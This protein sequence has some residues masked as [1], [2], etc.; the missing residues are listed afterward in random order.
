MTTIQR[1]CFLLFDDFSNHCLANTVEPLRAANSILGQRV[2]EWQFASITGEKVTSSSGL[3]VVPDTT[4][5][6]ANGDVL[7]VM[8][9]YGFRRFCDYKT[10]KGLSSASKRFSVLAGLDTGSWLLA[11]A[12]LLDGM[13]ATIHWDEL[14]SFSEVF[15]KLNAVRKRFVQDKTRISCSGAAAAFDLTLNMIARAHGPALALDISQLF[16]VRPMPNNTLD[17]QISGDKLITTALDIMRSNLEVPLKI[18]AIARK[19]GCSSRTLEIRTKRAYAMTPQ[20][21]YK[22]LRVGMARNLLADTDLKVAEISLR[23][24][25]ENPSAMS[26]AFRAEFQKTPSQMRSFLREI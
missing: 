6:R 20:A 26:R 5:Q 8:P 1:Y 11:E 9:S 25:Y 3:P 22:R 12:G 10:M 13:S 2:Y 7:F 18:S 17:F 21:I 15:P 16:M 24:G 4:L 19:I 23:C 14:Q